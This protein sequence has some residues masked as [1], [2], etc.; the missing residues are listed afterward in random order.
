[1]P[2]CRQVAAAGLLLL[3]LAGCKPKTNVDPSF[4]FQGNT[5]QAVAVIAIKADPPPSA[6]YT[7][8]AVTFQRYDP[9][10]SKLVP[11]AQNI[12]SVVTGRCPRAN[13]CTETLPNVIQVW[14][15]PAGSYVL[16]SITAFNDLPRPRTAKVTSLV[17]V[18]TNTSL[19]GASRQSVPTSGS[20]GNALR[21]QFGASEVVYLGDYV[22]DAVKFPANLKQIRRDDSAVEKARAARPGL[23]TASWVF[24]LPND[25]AGQPIQVR[26]FAGTISVD[27]TDQTHI[28]ATGG[29]PGGASADEGGA[30]IQ[31]ER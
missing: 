20:I 5:D 9:Q 23:A 22:I 14:R 31:I 3:A 4:S 6:A 1:M 8:L 29:T 17:G 12:F 30:V 11:G 16:K 18:Q 28:E 19:F 10:T 15:M 2:N 27:P 21:Y 7:R 24:R 25:E 26:D 13:A